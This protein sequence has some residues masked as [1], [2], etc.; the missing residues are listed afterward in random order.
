MPKKTDKK[1]LAGRTIVVTRAA[2]Q[3]ATLRESLQKAGASVL[4]LPLIHTVAD[5]NED[6]VE[7]M[8]HELWSYE[9]ILFTSPNGVRHFF[10]L[11]LKKFDDIRAL[12]GAHI[13]AIGPGTVTELKRYY[14]R[15]DVVPDIYTGEALADALIA[16]QTLDNLNILLITGNRS[17]DVIVSKLEEARAIVDKVQVYRTEHT[18]ISQCPDAEKFRSGGADAIIF[19]SGSAAESFAAQAARLKTAPNALRPAA[20]SIGAV[21]SE[22]MRKHGIPVDIEAASATMEA[23]IES[24]TRHFAS[25]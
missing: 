21:T 16:E 2:E 4:E 7:G 5:S 9:W 20:C 25:K 22:V 6:D 13:A 1:P 14:L 8:F 10:D 12:G 19:A 18:D 17:N 11:F 3:A 23:I 24:L 15:A